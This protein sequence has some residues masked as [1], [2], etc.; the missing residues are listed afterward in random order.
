VITKDWIA[1]FNTQNY[2]GEWSGI[3]L[4][5]PADASHPVLALNNPPGTTEYSDQPVLEQCPSL[6]AAME[7]LECPKQTARLLRLGPGAVIEEHRD[8]SLSL[9][10]EQVR[11]H[12]PIITGPW[13]D[14]RANGERVEMKAGELWY[15][16][17]SQPHSVANNGTEGRVHLVVDCLLNGWLR[18][19]F[20][21]AA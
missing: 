17:A 5:G 13:I 3:A 1:H 10:D 19:L 15:L 20:E 6:H 16:D 14:F 12:I 18:G 8:H 4:R 9:A 2:S 21:Q 11:L 7:A